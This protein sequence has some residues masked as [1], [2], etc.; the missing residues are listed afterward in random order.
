MLNF[1][2]DKKVNKERHNEDIR[3][4][5][6]GG[7][8]GSDAAM[9]LRIAERG[10]NGLSNTD[11]KRIAVAMGL[12]EPAPNYTNAAMEAGHA[13]EDEV[14]EVY[15]SKQSYERERLMESKFLAAKFRTFAHADFFRCT[16]N[17][18]KGELKKEV[19]ECKYSQFTTDEVLEQY[20]AQ[21]QWY[22]LLGADKVTL[23]HGW[24][25]V[26]PYKMENLR[27][28]EVVVDS[29]TIERL[30]EGVRYLDQA[31]ADGWTPV[32]SDEMQEADVPTEV[33]VA[34]EELRQMRNE[35]ETLDK[36]EA[37]AKKIVSDYMCLTD[38]GSIR[39]DGLVASYT[40]KM[41][42]KSFDSKRFLKEN[43][44]FDA[45]EWYKESEIAPT[46][47]IKY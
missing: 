17:S 8:G 28:I 10:V 24:G 32:P 15:E 42:R 20:N 38:T 39:G 40:K 43:P 34:L 6:I 30:T 14:A 19:L 41:V 5:R 31:I 47:R 45:E 3:Q 23:I 4:S 2:N 13:F 44:D 12:R 35:R 11:L 25:D 37:E 16:G 1:I 36:R 46:L 7:F 9:F 21:L 18:Q 27:R 22:Y 33:Q 26:E 29:Q